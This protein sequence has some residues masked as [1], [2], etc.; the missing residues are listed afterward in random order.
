MNDGPCPSGQHIDNGQCVADELTCSWE[1]PCTIMG[2]QC[3]GGW[4]VVVPGP[5]MSNDDCPV[6]D[7]CTSGMCTP[8]CGGASAQCKIDADCGSGK[9]CVACMCTALSQCAM[10]TPDLSGTPWSAHSDLHLDQALGS[11]GQAVVP[12]LKD[13]RDAIQGCPTLG[14]TCILLELVV[15]II[16]LPVQQLI[17]AIA[18]FGDVLDNHDFLVDSTMTFTANGKPSGYNVHEEWTLLT[19]HY[20]GMTVMSTPQNTPEIGRAVTMD[21]GAS[22]V[23]GVLYVDK[24][25]V[26]GV[27]AGILKWILDTVVNISTNGQCTDVG[28]CI[29]SAIDCAQVQDVAAQAACVAL[30]NGLANKLDMALQSWLLN[31]TFMTLKGTAQVQAWNAIING[32]WNGTLGNGTTLFNNFDGTWHAER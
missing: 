22:A 8:S 24:H 12:I 30:V 28:Q 3:V 14:A 18:D 32:H 21:Y 15:P 31:Y 6:G 2:Q 27:L 13:L 29:A 26:P 9:L 1:F 4:C 16:P 11:F 5:C 23:C 7:I 19:F 10:P 20:M 17:V 25:S